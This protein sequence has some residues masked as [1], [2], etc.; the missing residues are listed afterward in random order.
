MLGLS[1]L[2]ML[3]LC[4]RVWDVRFRFHTPERVN[5]SNPEPYTSEPV[6]PLTR[7]PHNLNA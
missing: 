2:G 1:G 6:S 3:G 5:P 4:F 7:I